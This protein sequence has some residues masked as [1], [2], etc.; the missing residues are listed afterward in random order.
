MKRFRGFLLCMMLGFILGTS[1]G[2]ITLWNENSSI[3]LKVF[4][5]QASMLPQADQLALEKGIY[6]TC[7]QQLQQLLEDYLS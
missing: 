6:I 2:Y 5:Y 4:P 1:N 7:P 3:P